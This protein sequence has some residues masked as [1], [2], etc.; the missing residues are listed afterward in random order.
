[1]L[2]KFIAVFLLFIPVIIYA[3]QY[4]ESLL[5]EKNFQQQ[6][7]EFTVTGTVIDGED[8]MPLQG[9][10]VSL[11]DYRDTTIVH[12]A[13]TDDSG[14]FSVSV[15][16]GSYI[17]RV[18][19]IGFRNVVLEDP[20]EISDPETDIGTVIMAEGEELEEIEVRA[21]RP[22]AILRGDTL[23]FHA[24][25]Y[26]LNPDATTEDLVRR[27]AG[28]RVDDDGVTAEG[29]EVERVLVDGREFF[30]DD[31]TV[32]L[33]NL[34][35]EVVERIEVYDRMSDQAELTGFDDGER[36]KTINIVT[37]LDSRSSQ[38]G[39]IYSGYGGYD[40]YQAGITTNIFSET[41]RLS[42]IGMSNNINEQNFSREDIM[43]LTAGSA[44]GGRG[45][46]G[47]GGP[48]GGMSGGGMPGGGMPHVRDFRM[49]PEPGENT[50]HAL[51]LNYSD[52]WLDERLEM[53]GS[54]FFNISDNYTDQ[55]TDREYLVDEYDNQVYFEDSESS[56]QRNNHRMHMRVT[57]DIDENN[58]LI[59]TP[60][61]TLQ[62]N[63]SDEHT[64]ARNLLSAGDPLSMTETFYDSDMSGYNFGGS[65][66]YRH[67]INDEG[68]SLS[69]RIN[70]NFNNNTSLYYLDAINEYFTGD[71]EGFPD[72]TVISEYMDQKS[73]S[74]TINNTL[75]SNITY[76]EPLG[77]N[78]MLQ[79][80]YNISRSANES[81]RITSS[82]EE[83]SGS[84]TGFEPDLST[85]LESSYLTHRGSLGYRLRGEGYNLTLEM[86]YQH[87]RL[88]A[89]QEFP[90]DHRVSRDF[91]NFL[92]RLM[93]NYNIGEGR[94]L[95]FT[96]RTNTSAPSVTQL[97]DVVD[98]T[99]PTL[100][101]SGNPDLDHSYSHFFMT[102]YNHTNTEKATNF[103]AFLFA[104]FTNNH[105]GNS[106]IIAR[107]D[108]TLANGLELPRG[109]QFSQPVNLD[110]Q[111]HIRANLDYGFPVRFIRSNLN[112]NGGLAYIRTPGLINDRENIANNYSVS[113]GLS[114]TS[115][116]S[117]NIDFTLSYRGTYNM[118]E[119]SIQP[120]MDNNYFYHRGGA[121]FSLI[122][123]ED[124]VF[125]SDL[126]HRMYAGL[127]DDFNQDYILWSINLG[128]KFFQNN[129]GEL[130]LS[131]FDLLGQNDNVMR[132]VSDMYVE[133]YR[134]NE[135]TR[136]FM[137]TFTYNLRN[138][139]L[140]DS[141]PVR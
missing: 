112:I 65:L 8:R 84:Y 27:M 83:E 46:G 10:H 105:I 20:V 4:D 141:P 107:S 125:R 14:V 123:L 118:V 15:S 47:G 1:M 117:Q 122:F 43:T 5:E 36:S 97:Q 35:A 19:F 16:P 25:A 137:L 116:I 130:T 50:T 92:P 120:E 111:A 109:S 77:E 62:N 93:L 79:A 32:A 96:Y 49:G 101:S 33:R 129:Q 52:V 114:L 113:G 89:D 99:N 26:R 71:G 48:P 100:L 106:T 88:S 121:R 7:E 38:F 115:N 85:R 53:T 135:L 69:T 21:V 82:F 94:N 76:T 102:R 12:N 103:V 45:G 139:N 80:S 124:W 138:F 81:D 127:G 57:Y 73:D 60:R 17:L 40:R 11:T 39:R 75:S 44:R 104:N 98:N 9:A 41:S 67:R 22:G 13:V 6:E 37:R 134:T 110:G 30:G 59:F 51:G 58:S 54:Y 23:D 91:T 108:T 3:R 68:R 55:L 56:S 86:G 34:P 61:L 133:D 132:N 28:I 66:L 128:R 42:I 136:Y 126:S 70:A 119:N 140:Q 24:A 18:S 78:G 90:Y 95:R 87:A 2:Q 29:E 74:E 31:P 64:Y 131:V 63:L 72:E